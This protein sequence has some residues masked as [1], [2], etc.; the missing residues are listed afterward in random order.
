M[1]QLKPVSWFGNHL[2]LRFE[3]YGCKM[4]LYPDPFDTFNSVPSLIEE[5]EMNSRDKIPGTSGNNDKIYYLTK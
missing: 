1:I 5:T 4:D 3:I 2:C